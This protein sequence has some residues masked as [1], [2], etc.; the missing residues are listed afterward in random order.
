LTSIVV[1]LSVVLSSSVH[2][3]G[4]GSIP[5]IARPWQQDLSD[6]AFVNTLDKGVSPIDFLL[7]LRCGSLRF[8]AIALSWK[9]WSRL[10]T[11]NFLRNLPLAPIILG[12]SLLRGHWEASFDSFVD[13]LDRNLGVGVKL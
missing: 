3:S 13:L 6:I 2:R 11:T 1:L 9:F 8:G 10:A 4:D 5:L 7:A 12:R